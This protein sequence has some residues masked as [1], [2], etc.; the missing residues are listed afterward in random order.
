VLDF[1]IGSDG[2]VWVL[3][4]GQWGDSAEAQKMVRVVKWD[5]VR[6][7]VRMYPCLSQERYE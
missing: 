3:L 1:V 7:E 5:S 4:D 6:E 2:L